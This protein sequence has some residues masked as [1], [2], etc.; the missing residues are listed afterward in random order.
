MEGG[1]LMTFV[2][3]KKIERFYLPLYAA[4]ERFKK[5]PPLFAGLRKKRFNK[6]VDRL[7]KE[8]SKHE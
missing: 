8:E 6:E 1:I 4:F 7:F 5:G 3:S 2:T